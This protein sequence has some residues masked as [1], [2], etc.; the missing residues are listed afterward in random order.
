MKE[1]A[2]TYCPRTS[3]FPYPAVTLKHTCEL[4]YPHL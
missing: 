4:P 2:V 3:D 1:E